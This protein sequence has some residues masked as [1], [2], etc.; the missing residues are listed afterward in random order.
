MEKLTKEK[1]IQLFDDHL[2]EIGA[3]RIKGNVFIPSQVLKKMNPKEYKSCY[4]TYVYD[5]IAAGIIDV[6]DKNIYLG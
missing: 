5:L 3:I 2:N 1:V 4:V 6:D